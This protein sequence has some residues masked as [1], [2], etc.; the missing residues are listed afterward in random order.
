MC[1]FK[2]SAND[3]IPSIVKLMP[4]TTT[5]LFIAKPP[6][7]VVATYGELYMDYLTKSIYVRTKDDCK[8]F[9]FFFKFIFEKQK[10]IPLK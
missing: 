10:Q 9:L 7:R 2:A 5:D 4:Y 3:E 8:L 6:E 1:F